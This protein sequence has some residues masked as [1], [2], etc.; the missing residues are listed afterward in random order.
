MGK[1]GGGKTPKV[2][3]PKLGN[4]EGDLN[5]L[6]NFERQFL[7]TPYSIGNY[8]LNLA[9]GGAVEGAGASGFQKYTGGGEVAGQPQQFGNSTGGG[10]PSG[11]TGGA[12]G[13]GGGTDFSSL[14]QQ[15][16]GEEAGAANTPIDFNTP[17]D[18]NTPGVKGFTEGLKN[19]ITGTQAQY[20]KLYDEVGSLS[21]GITSS[22]DPAISGLDR[23]NAGLLTTGGELLSRGNTLWD[24]AS[25]EGVTPSQAAYIDTQTAAS[26]NALAQQLAS[27]GLS[28]STMGA[29]LGGEMDLQGAAAKGQLVQGNLQAAQGEQGLG[30]S[31]TQAG[32]QGQEAAINARTAEQQLLQSVKGMQGNVLTSGGQLV[33]GEQAMI[34]GEQNMGLQMNQQHLQI[35]QQHFGQLAALAQQS[36]SAQAQYMQEALQG[37][38]LSGQFISNIL[39]PYGYQLQAYS[40]ALQGSE[41]QAQV[42]AG[43]QANA[44]QAQSQGMGSL[45]SGLGSLLGG[46]GGGGGGGGL[47]GGIL[48]GVGGMAGGAAAG[49]LGT[50]AVGLFSGAAAGGTAAGAS[51]IATAIGA[52]FCQ[53]AREV[54]G[55]KSP[56]WVHFRGWLVFEAPAWV[57]LLYWRNARGLAAWVRRHP[58]SKLAL[59][60]LMDLLAA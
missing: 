5:T 33:E 28:S 39:A 21:G 6:S 53:L 49:G 41:T 25:G 13:G 50:A 8:G 22:F 56:R 14:L 57:R 9:T 43:V 20:G 40:T 16:L 32:Q 38:G 3:V 48:G 31:A 54:Y 45:F 26:K 1:K 17:V 37:Y 55:V 19:T 24:E 60:P 15:F 51:A 29:E 10:D 36:S 42:A 44:A 59:R 47:L 30:V 46:G 11:G 18:A 35:A 52:A 7:T 58:W 34:Q 27:E 4:L 23:T 12:G 2:D